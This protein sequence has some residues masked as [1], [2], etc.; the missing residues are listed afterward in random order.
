MLGKFI[1]PIVFSFVVATPVVMLVA[2][3]LLVQDK[4]KRF[5]FLL[6][7]LG[8]IIGS[9]FGS[10]LDS[11][12]FPKGRDII[13]IEWIQIIPALVTG[14][15]SSRYLMRFMRTLTGSFYHILG[16]G[17]I[18]GSA[19]FMLTK[20]KQLKSVVRSKKESVTKS[21]NEIIS[22]SIPD[23]GTEKTTQPLSPP[24]KKPVSI[25]SQQGTTTAKPSCTTADSALLDAAKS[26]NTDILKQHLDAGANVNAS[27]KTLL[28]YSVTPLHEAASWGQKGNIELLIANGANVNAKDEAGKTPLDSATS[29]VADLLR[30]HGGKTG[31]ELK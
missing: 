18:G 29:E 4:A 25:T 7:F 12:R 1:E 6:I 23:S 5:R 3:F 13:A 20:P 22:S 19:A 9:S 14:D 11:D 31:E 16:G 10:W 2:I 21:N 15:D 28:G 27:G 24:S 26:N 17:F 30:K 8:L